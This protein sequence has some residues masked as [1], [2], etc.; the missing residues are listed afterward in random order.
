MIDSIMLQL[1][2]QAE[3]DQQAVYDALVEYATCFY[4][5]NGTITLSDWKDMSELT[6]KAFSDAGGA[7]RRE[8]LALT[9]FASQSSFNVEAVQNG[10][11]QEE[12]DQRLALRREALNVAR[13]IQEV[14]L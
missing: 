7:L 4:L 9:G 2:I 10:Y 14:G 6:Q 12:Y 3:F 8:S 11:T 13:K 5:A 1:G